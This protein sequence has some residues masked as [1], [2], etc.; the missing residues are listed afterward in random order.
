MGKQIKVYGTDT[1]LY[2]ALLKKAHELGLPEHRH[3]V[4]IICGA[5]S[6]AEA[7]RMCEA[8]GLVNVFRSKY[9]SITGNSCEIAVAGNGGI[10]FWIGAYGRG[11]LYS[12]AQLKGDETL[13][14]DED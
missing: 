3:Q 11:N 12:I 2:G 9:T 4:R 1:F 10:Y 8:E 13:E 5:T 14:R 6:M 7:N